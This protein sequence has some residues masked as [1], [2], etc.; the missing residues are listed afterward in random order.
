MEEQ[1]IE[2]KT[3]KTLTPGYLE[4]QAKIMYRQVFR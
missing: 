3:H 4:W 1:S 2:S